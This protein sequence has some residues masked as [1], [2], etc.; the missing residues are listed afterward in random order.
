MNIP[1]QIICLRPADHVPER[2]PQRA[3]GRGPGPGAGKKTTVF[4]WEKNADST[5]ASLLGNFL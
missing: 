4:N 5:Y 2:L 1:I 3:G